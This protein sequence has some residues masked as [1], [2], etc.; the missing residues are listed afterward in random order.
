MI[1][2]QDKD[3]KEFEALQLIDQ[4]EILANEGEGED[5]IRLYEKAAQIYLDFGS[6]IN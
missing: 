4:A 3:Q 2:N 6:Y 1:N 5:A